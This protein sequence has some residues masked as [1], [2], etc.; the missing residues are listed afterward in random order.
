MAAK[1]SN[2]FKRL[3]EIAAK[4]A[5]LSKYEHKIGA[6]ILK[7]GKVLSTGFNTNSTHPL[8]AFIDARQVDIFQKLM[9]KP[10]DPV[11][12]QAGLKIQQQRLA[13]RQPHRGRAP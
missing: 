10:R 2:K 11:E 8:P 7:H 6:V 4:V 12:K 9:Q 1:G 5:S 3:M 13:R